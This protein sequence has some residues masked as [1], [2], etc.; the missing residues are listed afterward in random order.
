[1]KEPEMGLSCIHVGQVLACKI[2]PGTNANIIYFGNIGSS[3]QNY[4][5]VTIINY[6]SSRWD[7]YY[8]HVMIV[9]LARSVS[10]DSMGVICNHKD[11]HQFAAYLYNRKNVYSSGHWSRAH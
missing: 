2:L 5:R 11:T 7:L 8:K 4:E 10:C 1:M 6:N 9:A 3:G